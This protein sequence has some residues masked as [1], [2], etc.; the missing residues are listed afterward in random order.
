MKNYF[1][2]TIKNDLE[3]LF[4]KQKDIFS[5]QLIDDKNV[6]YDGF[7]LAKTK[8]GNIFAVCD[9]NFQKSNTD[10]KYQARLTFRKTDN[11][12]K[13]R[14]VNKGTDC[15]R[16]AFNNRQD[17][18]RELWKMIAF[19]YK[20]RETIDL[21]E[22]ENYFSVTDEDLADILSKIANTQN[23]NTFVAGLEKLSPDDLVNIGNLVNT[24]NITLIIKE[25]NKNKDNFNEEFWQKLFQNY[26]WIL[27]QIFACPYIKIGEK[28]YCG[29]KEDDN[30]GGVL[31]DLQY[32]NDLTGNIAFIEIKT[33]RDNVLIGEKYRGEQGREN[34]I[35]SMNKEL[36]GSVNQVLNQKKV[37]IKTHGEQKGKTLNNTKCV[38]VI[39][40]SPTNKDQKKSFELYRSSLKDV[41]IITYD[42]LFGRIQNI[43]NIFKK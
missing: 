36:T 2:L 10:N 28:T 26:S 16:I 35:F 20:W 18:Y 1:D 5:C 3:K 4:I 34:M 33:P 25:W 19:L 39:G 13:E 6:I 17:G 8:K 14:N 9:I 11:E 37:Y 41:E 24:T 27:A 38:V 15:I 43:L 31:G 7:K 40:K 29:G 22:F 30:K 23:K 32:Q 21:G 12:F 42:E